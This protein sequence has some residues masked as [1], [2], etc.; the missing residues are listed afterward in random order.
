MDIVPAYLAPEFKDIVEWANSQP[1][2]IKDLR[3][4][5][6]LLDCWTYTCIFCLRTIPIMKRLQQKYSKKYGFLVIQAHSAEYGFARDSQNIQ[7]ALSYY[8]VNN[9]PV[10]FDTNNKTWEA[11]GNMYWPKHILI[12]HNS[13]IRYEHAGYGTIEEFENA[14]IELLDEAGYKSTENIDKEIPNDEIFDIYGMHFNG[15]APEICVGYSRL[16]RF[17]NNHKMKPN[18]PNIAVDPGFHMENVVYLSGK[19][20]WEREGVEV[21]HGSVEKNPAIMMRY[22]SAR[23]VHGIIGTSDG[24]MGRIEV[25]IDGNY[26]TKEQLG[27]HAKLNEGISYADIEWPFMHNLIRTEK[28]EVHEV[29]IIPRSDNF[30]FYTFAFG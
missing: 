5:V 22:N 2:F 23:R 15:I 8:D 7:K 18:E 16:R 1:L 19:W 4:K 3:G 12:D 13:F 11:Y 27:E 14:V 9:I 26:L 21:C 20:I 10:A 29:Q 24:K 30:I 28:A 6:L 25:K 17:G